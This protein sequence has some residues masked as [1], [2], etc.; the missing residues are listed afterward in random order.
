MRS[1]AG[2][3]GDSDAAPPRR[4]HPVMWMLWVGSAG[5][6]ALLTRNPWLL[7]LIG[8][9]GLALRA[10]LRA[11]QP[12][13]GYARLWLGML[14]FPAVLNLALSRAGDT[15]LLRLPLPLV[16]GPYTFEALLFG[17]TAGVQIASLLTVMS[18]L[19]LAVQPID[20][21]RRMPPG[22]Q[23][24]GVSASIGMSFAPQVARSYQ[25]L[26][27]A[28]E[29]RGRPLRGWRD[30]PDM[31]TP[32]LVL[33]LESALGLAEGMVA[34]GWAR[35]GLEGWRRWGFAAGWLGLA[36]ALGLWTLRPGSGLLGAAVFAAGA[37]LLALTLRGLGGRSRYRPERWRRA[38]S[39]TAGLA[40]GTAASF[41][42][43]AALSPVVLTYYPYPQAT[44]PPLPPALVLAVACLVAPIALIEVGRE[45]G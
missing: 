43:L 17:L 41:L 18:V 13:W 44:W 11:G 21:L 6:A 3:S 1:R 37:G 31:V 4:G 34:R 16:G 5:T 32:L 26:R 38:D 36:A 29:V 42:V 27:E 30:L 28:Q 10:R 9:I 12:G 19:T 2:G 7:L 8:A 22:L 35:G 15:V 20:L 33:S 23:P 40:L 45:T 14:L 25:A 24:A 39:L